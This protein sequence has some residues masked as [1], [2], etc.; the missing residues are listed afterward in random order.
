MY[1]RNDHDY[2]A[3]FLQMMYATPCEATR[4]TR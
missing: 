1:P 2:A 4:P 3:N